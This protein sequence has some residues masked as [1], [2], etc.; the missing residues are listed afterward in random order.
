MGTPGGTLPPSPPG[1]SIAVGSRQPCSVCFYVPLL[2]ITGWHGWH[3]RSSF[4][5]R[6]FSRHRIH[7]KPRRGFHSTTVVEER[8]ESGGFVYPFLV[9]TSYPQ[10]LDVGVFH[11][12][13]LFAEHERSDRH[14]H[15]G[16]L[17]WRVTG[18]KGCV[19]PCPFFSAF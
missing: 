8:D 3:T 11:H 7:R 14:R 1:G 6:C 18:E 17:S 5:K 13:R 9:P 4:G 2:S 16:A 12:T 15:G 19:K 10:V